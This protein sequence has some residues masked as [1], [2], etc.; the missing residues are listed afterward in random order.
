MSS[1]AHPR[2]RVSDDVKDVLDH[3]NTSVIGM[4]L[5]PERLDAALAVVARRRPVRQRK[6]PLR[7]MLLFCVLMHLYADEALPAVFA[8]LTGYWAGWAGSATRLLVS[9]GALC[10]ARYRLGVRPVVALFHLVCQPLATTQTPGAFLFGRRL[11]ALDSTKLDVPDSAANVAAFGRHHA[12]RGTSAWP[13]VRLVLLVECGTHAICDAG[14]WPCNVDEGRAGRRLLRVV[15]PSA[16]VLWDR[17]FQSVEMMESTMQRGADFLARLPAT[18]RPIP[19]DELAD[20]TLLVALR[21][22]WMRRRRRGDQ[23]V[24]RLIRYTLDDPQRPGH[25]IEHR[26]VTSLLDPAVAPARELALAYHQRWEIELVVD[27]LKT[28]QRPARPLRSQRPVGVLQEI[29]GLLIAHYLLR[30]LAATAAQ[31][32]RVAPTRVS[33]VATLRLLRDHLVKMVTLV[34]GDRRRRRAPCRRAD[35]QL[36]TPLSAWLLPARVERLNPRVVKQ[37]MTNFRVKTAAHLHWP[38]PTKP[39]AEALV[40][41]I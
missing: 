1:I 26:L 37:K 20:G 10:Q 8:H 5:P 28:H 21:P 27:E 29:Y 39:F 31:T 24:A 35:R 38:Q 9:A 33:F 22:G 32:A 7:F 4:A 15:G 34:T 18:V 11:F 36:F 13:Q 6:L 3:L 17:G 14:V 30:A 23:V 19:L 2:P 12:W 25:Q 16:L 40:L 41:L